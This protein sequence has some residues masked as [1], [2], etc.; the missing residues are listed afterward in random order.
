VNGECYVVIDDSEI[1]VGMTDEGMGDHAMVVAGHERAVADHE[2][3][4]CDSVLT[5]CVHELAPADDEDGVGH[6]ELVMRD[7]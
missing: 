2:V 4:M 6:H 3:S 5:F 1:G 7:R